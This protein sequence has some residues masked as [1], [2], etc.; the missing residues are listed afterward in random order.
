MK[1]RTR[2]LHLL[3][4]TGLTRTEM[5][6]GREH[7]VVP[8]VALREGVIH[9]VNAKN[10]EFVGV[11]ALSV[12]PQ[13]WNGRPLVLGHPAKDGR[14]ISANDAHVLE[15]QSFGQI[16][17][18]RVAGPKLLMDAYIDPVKAEKI[19]GASL[20]QRLRD[21]EMCEV[22]VGAYVTTSQKNGTYNGKAYKAEWVGISPDHLAFLP[23]SRGACS[24]EMGCGAPRMA[25]LVTAEGYEPMAFV[26]EGAEMDDELFA[27]DGEAALF[28]YGMR[29]LRDISTKARKEADASDFAG[30]NRSFPI[31]KS[32]DVS[33]AASSI[34][35]AGSDNYSTDEL[36]SR[37]ISIA[38]RKGFQGSL[39]ESWKH[40]ADQKAASALPDKAQVADT[41]AKCPLCK[42]SGKIRAGHVTCPDCKG[43]GLKALAMRR[44][45]GLTQMVKTLLAKL[46]TL[47]DDEMSPDATAELISYQAMQT[48][49]QQAEESLTNG[50]AQL[51]ALVDAE[52]EN[53]YQDDDDIEDARLEALI[54][55]CIQV[56]GTMN[57]IMKV[58][59]ASLSCNQDGNGGGAVNPMMA[60]MEHRAAIGAR[61]NAEDEATIQG[62]HDAAMDM[63]DNSVKLGAD[64]TCPDMK[65]AAEACGCE[66]GER[67]DKAQRSAAIKA[68]IDNKDVGL[69]PEA[70]RWLAGVPDESLEAMQALAG[71]KLLALAK[72]PADQIIQDK[73]NA[74]A[75]LMAHGHALNMVDAAKA[76]AA[77]KKAEKAKQGDDDES[78]EDEADTDGGGDDDD[79]EKD[80]KNA[81]A[82]AAKMRA[83][84]AAGMTVEEYEEAV[85]LRTAPDS[86]RTLV[87]EK[88]AS[89]GKERTTLITGLEAAQDVYTKKELQQRDLPELRKLAKMIG[90]GQPTIDYSGRGVARSA[91]EKDVF[92]NPPDPYA[93]GIAKRRGAVN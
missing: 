66:G 6:D 47:D 48:L 81:K 23:D 84:T 5:Y 9:A 12:S 49:I 52:T 70:A 26:E 87:E 69:T 20:L 15:A 83:A 57:G 92:S 1:Q 3:G 58:A 68:L 18:A 62:M 36:K 64:C 82:R 42:G 79:D 44:K 41:K 21:G 90:V 54:S 34:G 39:P 29:E 33:A 31:L 51:D 63:H 7:L 32:E 43:T 67:M 17:N 16:F 45:P 25:M 46:Q 28:A 11:A 71:A 60:Y 10:P 50:K 4:A 91:E 75:A 35:R 27:D 73:A 56:Y 24:N 89:D 53:P 14:Q 19:G 30:K 8:V 37:I 61:H 2:N 59:T 55:M 86:I 88:K 77:A 85:F 80:M 40:K 93:A 78:D 76:A 38:Y 22:S 72:S 65:A 74:D 13:S